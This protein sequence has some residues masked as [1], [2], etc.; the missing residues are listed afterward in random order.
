VL[1]WQRVLSKDERLVQML[2][3]KVIAMAALE[4]QAAAVEDLCG[5]V[6][7]PVGPCNPQKGL[8]A[9]LSCR[10]KEANAGMRA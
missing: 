9:I 4:K 3:K 10:I 2:L 8:R 7:K 5:T 1:L 6:S